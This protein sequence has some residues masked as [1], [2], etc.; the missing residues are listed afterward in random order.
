MDLRLYRKTL[1]DIYLV[2]NTPLYLFEGM[3]RSPAVSEYLAMFSA[4]DLIREFLNRIESPVSNG[5]EIAE[6]Y[7]I[8]I[9]LTFKDDDDVRIFFTS[10]REKI[11][12][13][14]F[15][16]IADYYLLNIISKSPQFIT[17]ENNS[18]TSATNINKTNQFNV[19][20]Q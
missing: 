9:A 11:K 2:S 12:F 10:V 4:G 19:I 5:Y 3:R 20:L 13:E 8:Y 16:K 6:I 7:A 17:I 1:T 15:S 18:G 14:W